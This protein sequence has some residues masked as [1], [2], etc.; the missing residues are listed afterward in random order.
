[1]KINELQHIHQQTDRQMQGILLGAWLLSFVYAG[2]YSTW[3][4]ALILGGIIIVPA[5]VLI[6]SQSGQSLTRHVVCI[7]LLL[8][9]SLHV[10][11]LNGMVEAHFGYFVV[12]AVLFAYK[13]WTVFLTAAVVAAIHHFSFYF[14]Q[15]SGTGVMLFDPDNLSLVIVLQHA[16]YV[17]IECAILAYQCIRSQHEIALVSSLNKVIGDG[18]LDFT[19]NEGKTDNPLLKKLNTV[20]FNTREALNEV[21]SSNRYIVDSVEQVTSSFQQFDENSR[22]EVQGTIEIASATEQMVCTFS[23]M[24]EDANNAF[25]KVQ[26]A[27]DCNNQTSQAMHLSQE[28]MTTLQDIINNANKT[29][30]ELSEQSQQISQVLQVINAISEQTNLLALNAAIEAARAGESGR[31]FAVVADEVRTLAS[32]TRESVDQTHTIISQIQ[33][34][35]QNAV[36]DMERCLN[37]I[38]SSMSISDE[39][40]KEMARA[41]E[42]IKQLAGLNEQMATNINQQSDVSKDIATNVGQIKSSTEKNGEHISLVVNSM[43]GLQRHSDALE[44]QLNRFVV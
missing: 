24:V 8:F 37:Q 13:D 19:H 6:S 1:M 11:Q 3:M 2:V 20:I 36:L 16:F 18:Q 34:S 30:V 9:V 7:T 22:Q 17:V 32:R 31:G 27:V 39:V 25:E 12:I 14:L 40:N 38:S 42:V 33:E 35:G 4:E 29:I 23:E 26:V 44:T 5:F 10:Q 41:N 43:I 21:K 28:S 15:V